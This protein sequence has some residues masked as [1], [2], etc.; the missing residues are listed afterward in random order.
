MARSNPDLDLVA[1]SGAIEGVRVQLHP[2]EALLLGRA[3]SGLQIPDELVSIYHAEI[4][5]ENGAYWVNDLGS[6]TGSFVDDRKLAGEKVKLQVGNV[7][8]V[9]DTR[10]RV[11][12]RR[13]FTPL[14]AI[15]IA[16]PL[17]VAGVFVVF[18]VFL[19]PSRA[20]PNELNW[21]E[22]IR[23]GPMVEGTKHLE[24]APAFLRANGLDPAELKIRR[25]TDLDRNGVDEVWIRGTTREWI[26]T[27]E[28]DGAWYQL[29]DLPI[30][31]MD[32]SLTDRSGSMPLL[33]CPGV[34]YDMTPSGYQPA[35]QEGAVV[36]LM[37]K[38]VD[39]AERL[40]KESRNDAPVEVPID[41]A[42]PPPP[43]K[44]PKASGSGGG[45]TSLGG[46]STAS[47]RGSGSASAGPPRPARKEDIVL[48]AFERPHR[49]SWG[50]EE[51]LAGFLAARGVEEPI[52]YL[53][54]ENAL[55]GIA[56]QVLTERGEIRPLSFGCRDAV[57]LNRDLA[58]VGRP[59]IV[60]FTAH[61]HS[62]LVTDVLSFYGGSADALY[63]DPSNA[64]DV[65]RIRGEAGLANPTIQIEWEAAPRYVPSV[66]G[67]R[68]LTLMRTLL[69]VEGGKAVR[70]AVSAKLLTAGTAT[71]DPPGCSLL[72]VRVEAF[73]CQAS[74]GC[75]PGS[76]FLTVDDTGCG[77]PVRVLA[78]G[79]GA[80][81]VDGNTNQV[82][83][84]AVIETDAQRNTSTVRRARIAWRQKDG[85]PTP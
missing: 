51:K 4:T 64:D 65:A 82:E 18:A 25:V 46:G 84:R 17:A 54:C 11:S 85:A 67:E 76:T 59:A 21:S 58:L 13:R 3:S 69:P 23:R 80:S 42:E 36:W 40:L 5:W 53:I 32:A 12:T 30:G 56:P 66:A 8:R 43:A 22:T 24:V 79:Y 77:A 49:V 35:Q 60:A 28:A 38:R 7:L 6:A 62:A 61:G 31:C 44:A 78:V 16:A 41:G 68:P 63:L 34:L 71:L 57:G 2:R 48:H 50:D 15:A 37:P 29:G 20:A 1:T 27:F 73:T 47:S 45:L 39:A 9:G 10:L 81:V 83:V 52:H 19:G 72:E 74:R 75:L 55:T 33:R 14:E 26:V 70:P